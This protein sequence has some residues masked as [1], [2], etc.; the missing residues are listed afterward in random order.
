MKSTKKFRRWNADV[1][2]GIPLVSSPN[3]AYNRPIRYKCFPIRVTKN[4]CWLLVFLEI[5]I[6]LRW[7]DMNTHHFITNKFCWSLLVSRVQ[8]L[9]VPSGSKWFPSVSLPTLS[10][11]YISFSKSQSVGQSV[12]QPI[13]MVSFHPSFYPGS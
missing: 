2:G 12:N 4:A 1:F 10:P 11:G 6:I 3:Q 13:Q 5:G 8:N 7:S 9:V